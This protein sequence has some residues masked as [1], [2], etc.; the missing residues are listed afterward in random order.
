MGSPGGIVL[1]TSGAIVTLSL[2]RWIF[3]VIVISHHNMK[4]TTSAFL[5]G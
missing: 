1:L 3:V 2:Q 4:T 5:T